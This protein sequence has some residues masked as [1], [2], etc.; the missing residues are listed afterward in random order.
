[1]FYKHTHL[2]AIRRKPA[3]TITTYNYVKVLSFTSRDASKLNARAKNKKFYSFA[4]KHSISLEQTKH[5]SGIEPSLSNFFRYP[6][7]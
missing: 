5:L 4:L 7:P 2:R 3:L 1:M 6:K